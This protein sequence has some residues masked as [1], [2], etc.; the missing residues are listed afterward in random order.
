MCQRSWWLK[1]GSAGLEGTELVLGDLTGQKR[2]GALAEGFDFVT[3]GLI[4]RYLKA[5]TR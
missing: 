1:G 5:F 2:C 3:Y 4:V